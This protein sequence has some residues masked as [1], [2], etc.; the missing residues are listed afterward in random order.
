MRVQL[1][2]KQLFLRGADLVEIVP[3]ERIEPMP[4]HLPGLSG[5]LALR[6]GP[7][8]VLDWSLLDIHPGSAP[9]VAVLRRRLGL[10]IERIV[11]VRDISQLPT[12]ELKR[13]DSLNPVLSHRCRLSGQSHGVLEVE[14]LLSILHNRGFRR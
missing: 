12:A 9:L 8:P 3:L 13:G 7:L 1:G 4:M 10:P 11:E 14:K 5:I 6:S 2:G